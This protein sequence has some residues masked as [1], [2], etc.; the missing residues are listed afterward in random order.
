MEAQGRGAIVKVPAEFPADLG[1]QWSVRTP[2]GTALTVRLYPVT[3][4]VDADNCIACGRCEE[5]CPYDVA[6]VGFTRDA[7]PVCHIDPLSCRGCG[8]CVGACP[9]GA[10]RQGA[11]SLEAL[12]DRL[13]RAASEG[14]GAVAIVCHWGLDTSTF[15]SYI[16]EGIVDVQSVQGLGPSL[17][18]GALAHGARGVLILQS[19]PGG[20]HFLD[21]ERTPEELAE[22]VK[23]FLRAAGLGAER[24]SYVEM[25]E[26]DRPADLL[27]RFTRGLDAGGVRP[28]PAGALP[29]TPDGATPFAQATGLMSPASNDDPWSGPRPAAVDSIGRAFGA[30]DLGGWRASLAALRTLTGKDAPS[31]VL[32]A[33]AAMAKK[34]GDGAGAHGGA[35]GLWSSGGA[36]EAPEEGIAQQDRK[37]L[38]VLCGG[39]DCG[40]VCSGLGLLPAISLIRLPVPG[41]L[42]G[43]GAWERVDREARRK[44]I[45][46][47]KEARAGGARTVVAADPDLLSLARALNRG[48]GWQEVDVE[49]V[50]PFTYVLRSLADRGVKAPAGWS[51]KVWGGDARE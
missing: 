37:V 42:I 48:G 1:G 13:A 40:Y 28:L 24:V 27:A 18:T 15:D 17:I 50:D 30:G 39:D 44:I 23:D 35:P 25:K 41:E 46:L 32:E 33:A 22:A 19:P 20:R 6:R 21:G 14:P 8:A 47:L 38:A 3:A 11:F 31:D 51:G 26:G 9:T 36:E 4:E 2:N 34:L 5:V 10:I 7:G 49:A 16:G 43:P 45:A 29:E 12:A